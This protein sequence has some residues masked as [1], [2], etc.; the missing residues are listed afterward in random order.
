VDVLY[1]VK[2]R[3]HV[4]MLDCWEHANQLTRKHMH[5]PCFNWAVKWWPP[6][7]SEA[8][9][10]TCQTASLSGKHPGAAG[11]WGWF[12]QTSASLWGWH[13]CR[14]GLRHPRICT[15]GQL[16]WGLARI[17]R[18]SSFMAGFVQLQGLSP[19]KS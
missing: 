1:S 19:A 11:G 2:I 6:D 13:G 18:H 17:S 9:S 7:D 4:K 3:W 15:G 16:W 14:R 12:R 10:L 8:G 5:P